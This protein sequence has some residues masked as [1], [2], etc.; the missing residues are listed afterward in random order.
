[1]ESRGTLCETAGTKDPRYQEH[2]GR[3]LQEARVSLG[4]AEF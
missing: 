4:V 2:P 3:D 1:M